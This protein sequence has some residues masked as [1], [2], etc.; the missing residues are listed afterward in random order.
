VP[1]QFEIVHRSILPGPGRR[2]RRFR[3]PHGA[4]LRD[5]RIP[6]VTAEEIT[7]ILAALAEGFALRHLGD[8]GAGILG[9]GAA[10]NLFGKAILGILHSY[11]E[12]KAEPIG[13]SLRADFDERAD[14][15]RRDAGS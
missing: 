8:P 5:P 14:R 4:H 6:V 10:G 12:P 9:N 11:L 3:C 2:F 1:R 15:A 13:R 7:S